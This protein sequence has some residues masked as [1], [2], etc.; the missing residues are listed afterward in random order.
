VKGWTE[1]P[2]EQEYA[3]ATIYIDLRLPKDGTVETM[4]LATPAVEHR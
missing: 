2:T 3:A 4:G 1:T